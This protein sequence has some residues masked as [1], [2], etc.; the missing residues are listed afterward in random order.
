[1]AAASAAVSAAIDGSAESRMLWTGRQVELVRFVHN[2][3]AQLGQSPLLPPPA[4]PVG[5]SRSSAA[6]SLRH[7]ARSDAGDSTLQSSA[8]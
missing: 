6:I 4:P 7:A 3:V 5:A 1:M 2:P 8:S